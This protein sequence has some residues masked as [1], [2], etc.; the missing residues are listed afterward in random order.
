MITIDT[1]KKE[2]EEDLK[3]E[4]IELDKKA[5]SIPYLHGKYLNYLY[6]EKNK[7]KKLCFKRNVLIKEKYEYYTGK[8][9]EE[10]LKQKNIDAFPHKILKT[11]V[12]NYI[13]ADSDYIILQNQIE[14]TE[15]IIFLLENTLK[16]IQNMHWC[17]RSAIDWKKFINGA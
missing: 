14:S 3:I 17:I 5:L 4:D 8:T 12:E 6:D 2:I 1:L 9:S 15:N 7:L 11:E 10:E 13:K 16:N